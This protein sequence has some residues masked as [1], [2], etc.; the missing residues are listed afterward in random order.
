MCIRLW[1]RFLSADLSTTA[2]DDIARGRSTFMV[3]LQETS[4]I[5]QLATP[6]SLVVLDELG[7]GT[8]TFDGVRVQLNSFSLLHVSDIIP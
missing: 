4:S 8:S 7:R 5:L 3:E 1:S 2:S 6:R